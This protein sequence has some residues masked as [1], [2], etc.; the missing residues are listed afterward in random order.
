MHS[1]GMSQLTKTAL[2]KKIQN[3]RRSHRAEKK[4][5]EESKPRSGDPGNAE[6]KPKLETTESEAKARVDETS[7]SANVADIDSK[8]EKE[9]S[10]A[11]FRCGKPNHLASA[12]TD[13]K[14]ICYNCGKRGSH[15]QKDCTAPKSFYPVTR[16]DM[17]LQC[18]LNPNRCC[19]YVQYLHSPHGTY[20]HIVLILSVNVHDIN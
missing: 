12:C 9:K 16:N 5:V 2:M 8:N 15:E 3:L 11:C 14:K 7:S 17:Q 20:K 6:Y 4:K 19:T 10:V 1:A 13:P 18:I